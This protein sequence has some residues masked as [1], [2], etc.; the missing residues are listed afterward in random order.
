MTP[1]QEMTM[2]TFLIR[3]TRG[4][5]KRVGRQLLE[6]LRMLMDWQ[7]AALGYL[8]ESVTAACLQADEPR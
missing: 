7:L 4:G 1:D 6:R 2:G 3:G 8:P 5:E